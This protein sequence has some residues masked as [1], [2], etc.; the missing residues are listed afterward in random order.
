[1]GDQGLVLGAFPLIGGAFVDGEVETLAES[2]NWGNPQPIQVALRTLLQDGQRT[3][4]TGYDN[5]EVNIRVEMSATDSETLSRLEAELRAELGKRSQ[6]VWTPADGWGPPTLF[7]VE[8]SWLNHDMDDLAEAADRSLQR[9]FYLITLVCQPFG[10]SVNEVV[11][12]T[13]ELNPTTAPLTPTTA[14]INDASSDTGWSRSNLP[15]SVMGAYAMQVDEPYAV[16]TDQH[17][18][19][20]EGTYDTSVT[21]FVSV[22]YLTG[23]QNSFRASDLGLYYGDGTDDKR[24]PLTAVTPSPYT[25]YLRAYFKV[26]DAMSSLTR[27]WFRIA[28]DV[29]YLTPYLAAKPT[30]FAITEVERTNVAPFLGTQ[31]QKLRTVPVP[32]TERTP[33]SLVI[34]HPSSALGDVLAFTWRADRCPDYL[35]SLRSRRISGDGVVLDPSLVSGAYDPIAAPWVAEVLSSQVPDGEG[36]FVARLHSD[37]ATTLDINWA[38]YTR[39]GGVEVSRVEGTARVTFVVGWQNVTLAFD[40]FLNTDLKPGAPAVTRFQMQRQASSTVILLDEAWYF[41]T[42]REL[43]VGGVLSQVACGTGTPAP[44]GPSSKL[45]I[46]TATVDRPY[47]AYFRGTAMDGSDW[48]SANSVAVGLPAHEFVPTSMRLLSVT[49]GALDASSSIRCRPAFHTHATQ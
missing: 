48:F 28:I 25:G 15:Y 42:D 46:E 49:A 9:R 11:A 18:M 7:F 32:G 5:R 16:R 31:R 14:V 2:T 43:G 19:V 30:Y 37:V 6:L 47:P 27:L 38:V 40:Q 20:L 39:V 10:Y 35:P 23:S 33:A 8:T 24:I 22:D 26:P 29:G 17:L 4:I 45:S 1:M 36:Q 3:A 41:N 44:G 21:K 12:D 34:A 13:L